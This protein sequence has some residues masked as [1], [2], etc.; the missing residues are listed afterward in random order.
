MSNVLW[1]TLRR[2]QQHSRH[3]TRHNTM[4]LRKQ[5]FVV[6]G[7]LAKTLR[8]FCGSWSQMD[9]RFARRVADGSPAL[10]A[11]WCELSKEKKNLAQEE[12]QDEEY[13][14]S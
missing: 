11:R 7:E 13:P 4:T 14:H 1:E 10:D 3:D 6:S 2:M 12:F 5:L 9:Q 8:G